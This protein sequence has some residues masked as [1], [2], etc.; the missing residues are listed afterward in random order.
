[1]S[2]E[3]RRTFCN[4]FWSG[5]FPD[6][7]I[8]KVRGH[9]YAYGT[10]GEKR[11]T[12]GTPVFPILTSPDLVQWSFV[13][14]AMP[15]LEKPFFGYWAPE[16]TVQNNQF[17]LYYAVHTEEFVASIR[18]AVA[19]RP[20]GPFF[21][22]GRDLTSHLVPWAID[23]HV[24]RDQDGQ[25]YLYMTIEL[26]DNPEGFIGVGN[27]VDRLLGPFTLQGNLTLVTP[28]RHDWQLYQAKRPERKGVD[29]YTVEGPAVLRHRAQ[30]YQM[31]SG[32]CYYRDNYAVN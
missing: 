21:D 9:Y 10:E 6:P 20:E 16:V 11:P 26:W 15:A 4:P 30:Y 1:M 29:W 14:K 27:V 7:F 25:W 19:D 13:S 8:L 3:K 24:F 17:L 32:G 2:T 22:S 31:F 12:P 28:P 23:P 18:V 5:N